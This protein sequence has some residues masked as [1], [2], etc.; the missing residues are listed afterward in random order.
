MK[1]LSFIIVTTAF[2][3]ISCVTSHFIPNSPRS[4]PPYRGYVSILYEPPQKDYEIIGTVVSRGEDVGLAAVIEELRQKTAKV[5]GNA[6]IM[7]QSGNTASPYAFPLAT[8][9]F[10]MGSREIY[11]IV[12]TAIFIK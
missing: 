7:R 5:G 11:E 1:R 10:I 3:L 2:L 12:G 8:G 9:G 4:F 6:V